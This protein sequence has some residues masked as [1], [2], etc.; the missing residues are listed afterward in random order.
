[1]IDFDR[2]FASSPRAEFW[3][4]IK[5][6]KTPCE[7]RI[8]SGNKF[9]FICDNCACNHSFE[10]PLNDI[11]KGQW[12]PYCVNR[13]LCK[14]INC[15]QCHEK[16]FASSPRAVFWDYVKNVK[17]TPREVSKGSGK[18]FWFDCHECEHSFESI[19]KNVTKLNSWCPYC[20]NPPQ[21]M[22]EDMNC[23]WCHEKSFASS[24]RAIFWSDIN[25]KTPCEVFKSADKKYWFT[26]SDKH[27]FDIRLHSV[28]NNNSW[29]PM[30]K[31]KTEKMF[32]KWFEN[33]YDHV[34]KHQ[35]KFE[36]CK[37]KRYLPF[38]FSIESLKL[39][40]EIDGPQHYRQVSNWQSPEIT[41]A[42][43]KYK[44]QKALENGYTV[45]RILQED[46]FKNV[47]GWGNELVVTIALK[48]YSHIII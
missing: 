40:I 48:T 17:K 16:S 6:K 20:S 34:I 32:L 14:D 5:N 36:W 11:A 39:I 7:M 21:R 22:C 19:L 27:S 30:C 37:D 8:S 45:I 31:N 12:C 46:I 18:K 3:D 28:T 41:Q 44:T 10:T 24:P 13:K 4:Y 38:D 47:V 29:C 43:D 23:T 35:A 42:R 9:W 26:C 1:M 15:T 33:E 2:S 25:E